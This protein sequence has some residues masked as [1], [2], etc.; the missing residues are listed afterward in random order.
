MLDQEVINVEI[1]SNQCP[2][3]LPKQPRKP[4]PEGV[5]PDRATIIRRF[6]Q[7]WVNGTELHYCF[8]DHTKHN[9]PKEWTAKNTESLK[10]VE[11]AFR[12]WKE[13]GIGLEF[14][15]V[16]DP[17]DAEIRIGFMEGD[18]NWSGVGTNILKARSNERTMNFAIDFTQLNWLPF[19][20][21]LHE[22]GHTLGFYHGH[23]IPKSKIIWND[24]EVYRYYSAKGWSDS[25]IKT[26]ILD[27]ESENVLDLFPWDTNSVM[28][29]RFKSTLI[30]GPEPYNS[31]GISHTP[32]LS[33][34]DKEIVRKLYPPLSSQN[35][36]PLKAYRSYS[37]ILQSGEQLAFTIKPDHS[38]EFTF[39]TFGK[40]DTVLVLFEKD[41]DSHRYLSGD[42]DAGYNRNAMITHKLFK[43]REYV[44]RLKMYYAMDRGETA[45]MMF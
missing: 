20:T 36:I 5:S 33:P 25:D 39:Q 12:E 37:A 7:I 2:C 31:K 21:A 34:L 11:R 18:G 9:C 22:I 35:Y 29:Y 24:E 13:L 19:D 30:S 45:V 16:D 42:D 41:G 32:Y 3:Q 26:N 4:L 28:H 40:V 27:K 17:Y 8:W 10:I 6:G 38:R 14:I 44:L 43:D 23:Q 1:D 15:K